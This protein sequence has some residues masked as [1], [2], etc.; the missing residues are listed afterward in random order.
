MFKKETQAKIGSNELDSIP[1]VKL[2]IITLNSYHSFNQ[3]IWAT[4]ISVNKIESD[5]LIEFIF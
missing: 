4:A 3:Q 5:I 1:K 2:N